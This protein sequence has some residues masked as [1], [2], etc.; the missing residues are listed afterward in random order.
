MQTGNPRECELRLVSLPNQ[1]PR[2]E[3][4]LWKTRLG[5]VSWQHRKKRYFFY[6]DGGCHYDSSTLREIAR[7]V[8]TINEPPKTEVKK[9]E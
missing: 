1:L 7:V 6:P 5:S 8:D 3:L 2:Y 9:S 4:Y